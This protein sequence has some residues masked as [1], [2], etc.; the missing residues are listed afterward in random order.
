MTNVKIVFYSYIHHKSI[1]LHQTNTKMINCPF[2]AYCPIYFT[3][4]YTLFVIFIYNYAGGLHV[5]AATCKCTYLFQIHS[6]AVK[7]NKKA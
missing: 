5:A 1:D 3:S 2:Y 7:V 6:N 4:R